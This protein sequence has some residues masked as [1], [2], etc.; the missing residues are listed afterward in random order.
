M[1]LNLGPRPR[2]AKNTIN[3]DETGLFVLDAAIV[4]FSRGL[5]IHSSFLAQNER[6]YRCPTRVWRPVWFAN[7]IVIVL[8][9]TLTLLGEPSPP[10]PPPGPPFFQARFVKGRSMF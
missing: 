10:S 3:Q 1:L 9:F 2:Q 8:H 6:I 7:I 4:F 5:R